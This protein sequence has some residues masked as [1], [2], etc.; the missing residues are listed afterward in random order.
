MIRRPPRSTLF[1]Y[2]TLFRSHCNTGGC[3]LVGRRMKELASTGG[4][5]MVVG[6]IVRNGQAFVPRAEDQVQQG[7][8]VYVITETSHVDRV[9]AYL[10]HEEQV[11]RRIVIVG[12]GNVGLNLATRIA[13]HAPYVSLKMV[14]HS[15]DRAEFIS[16]ELGDAA[17]V[18]Q[19]D[20]LDKEVLIEANVQ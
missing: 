12:G 8:D 7:D 3:S 19:G 15:R 11:A 9:M 10:G 16:R 5:G 1:P 4:S 2:T 20:A 14:E 13:H 17:V 6:V 18:I